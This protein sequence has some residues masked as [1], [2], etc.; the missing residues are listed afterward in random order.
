MT[1]QRTRYAKGQQR[2]T[3]FPNKLEAEYGL[4]L[5]AEKRQ[6]LIRDYRFEAVTL[7]LADD[8]RLTIDWFVMAADDV[9]EMREV[10]GPH[11]WEDSIIKLRV[12]AQMYPF[13]FSLHRKVNGAWE[14]KPF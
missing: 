3:R 13:R 4:V 11:A 9:I 7:K 14:S 8:C 6:G 12:A 2:K 10:K 1:A 5:E